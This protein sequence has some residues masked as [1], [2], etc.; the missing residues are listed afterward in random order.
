MPLLTRSLSPTF[1]AVSQQ[2]PV[3]PPCGCSESKATD[4]WDYG[5][6]R[7]VL[8][9]QSPPFGAGI[10]TVTVFFSII[11]FSNV[12]LAQVTMATLGITVTMGTVGILT[13]ILL[14]MFLF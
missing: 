12:L 5:F 13:L 2:S 1:P 9:L 8:Q 10:L 6:N 14:I 3:S 4:P 7:L 11:F